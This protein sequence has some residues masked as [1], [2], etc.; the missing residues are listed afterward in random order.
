MVGD[1]SCS[2]FVVGIGGGGGGVGGTMMSFDLVVVRKFV[3]V[4]K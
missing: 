3:L 2:V 1:G 4:E